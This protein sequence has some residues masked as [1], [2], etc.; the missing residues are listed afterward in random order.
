MVHWNKERNKKVETSFFYSMATQKTYELLSGRNSWWQQIS[1]LPF[2]CV[3]HSRVS[4]PFIHSG[5]RCLC[6]KFHTVLTFCVFWSLL[7]SEQRQSAQIFALLIYCREEKRTQ[8]IHPEYCLSVN[9]HSVSVL[10]RFYCASFSTH[11]HIHTHTHKNAK[12]RSSSP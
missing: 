12:N 2:L 4:W 8:F 5:R 11:T 7:I 10:M 3:Y 6:Q 9:I 1:F